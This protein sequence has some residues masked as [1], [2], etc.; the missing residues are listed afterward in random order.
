MSVRSYSVLHRMFF[1]SLTSSTNCFH[2]HCLPVTD[3]KMS[4]KNES[5]ETSGEASGEVTGQSVPL[6]IPNQF[7]IRQDR[8]IFI[9]IFRN[10]QIFSGVIDFCGYSFLFC[11]NQSFTLCTESLI[12]FGRFGFNLSILVPLRV[13]VVSLLS[14]PKHLH[15]QSTFFTVRNIHVDERFFYVLFLLLY[16]R[17]EKKTGTIAGTRSQ[18]GF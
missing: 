17:Q 2:D 18:S 10:Y 7:N 12:C 16:S 5:T 15:L 1:F 8:S 6:A 14:S 4:R 9:L 11:S 13:Q 3:C